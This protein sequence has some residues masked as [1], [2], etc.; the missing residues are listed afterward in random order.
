MGVIYEL[1]SLPEREK[2]R[3]LER[4]IHQ[5]TAEKL[6]PQRTNELKIQVGK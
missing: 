6:K 2:K 5:E 1:L 3:F 4:I